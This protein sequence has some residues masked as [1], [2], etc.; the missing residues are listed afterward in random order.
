MISPLHMN[1]FSESTSI[2]NEADEMTCTDKTSLENFFSAFRKNII[3]HQQIFESPFGEKE[4]VYADWTASGRAYQPIEEFIQKEIMPFIANTH[5]ETTITGTLMSK[6]YEK[7]KLIIKQHINANTD[8]VLIFCGSGMT[9]AVNKLQR[10]LGMR[11]PARITEYLKKNSNLQPDEELK[12]VVFVTHMEHHSN[13]V[14]WSET[15][16]NVEIIN[17]T[18]NGNVDLEHLRSLLEQ[19]KHRKNKIAAVT[20]CSNVTGI[21]T[22]YREIA[23]MIHEYGGLCFVDFACSAPYVNIDMHPTENGKHIDALYFS[24]HKFLGGPGTP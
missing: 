23:K 4:I 21:E 1:L 3:G 9:S 14:S 11:M 15:I 12:P 20:A 17:P 7:A 8:D 6:A 10:I 22:P 18:D 2:I 16:A 24:P 13:Q 19:F 5:T